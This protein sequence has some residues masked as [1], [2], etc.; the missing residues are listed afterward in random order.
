MD[1]CSIFRVYALRVYT[2]NARDEHISFWCKEKLVLNKISLPTPTSLPASKLGPTPA[3]CR[4]RASPG[5]RKWQGKDLKSAVLH[6]CSNYFNKLRD[7]RGNVAAQS[8][9]R[10]W[11][12]LPLIALGLVVRPSLWPGVP[13]RAPSTQMWSYLS[14]K[15]QSCHS[16][17]R[18]PRAPG[19]DCSCWGSGQGLL[20]HWGLSRRHHSTSIIDRGRHHHCHSSLDPTVGTP[21]RRTPGG[22]AWLLTVVVVHDKPS[23]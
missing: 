8:P 3:H 9:S 22:P 2:S 14:T 20:G 17:L 5:A 15:R 18:S 10:G 1:I 23:T 6:R 7:K 16:R 12:V 21:S 13:S 4:D 11:G 19:G